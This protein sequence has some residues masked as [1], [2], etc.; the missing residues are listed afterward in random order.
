MFNIMVN[1]NEVQK[2]KEN[3]PNSLALR[4]YPLL[5]RLAE[6]KDL[7]NSFRLNSERAEFEQ[8]EVVTS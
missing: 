1:F 5:Q 8:T 6:A 3:R 4:L 2:K 7:V